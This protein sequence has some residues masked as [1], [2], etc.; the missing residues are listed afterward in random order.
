MTEKIELIKN[1]SEFTKLFEKVVNASIGVIMV[2]TREPYRA[3]DTLRRYCAERHDPADSQSQYEFILWDVLH[4]LQTFANTRKADGTIVVETRPTKNDVTTVDL[5]KAFDKISDNAQKKGSINTINVLFNPQPFFENVSIQQHIK[6]F[7]Q[8]ALECAHRIVMLCQEGADIPPAIENDVF[9]I[10]YLTPSMSELYSIWE[11]TPLGDGTPATYFKHF[12]K[13]EVKKIIQNAMGMSASEFENALAF[14]MTDLGEILLTKPESVK[15]EYIIDRLLKAKTDIIKKTDIL[16]L[17]HVGDLSNVGGLDLLKG[18]LKLRKGI[19][20]DKAK[21]FGIDSPKGIMLVGSPGCVDCD[22]EYFNGDKWVPIKDYQEGDF[23]LQYNKDGTA[24]MVKPLAYIKGKAD[25]YHLK[26]YTGSLDQVLSL[27]HRVIYVTSK[28]NIA[29]K[30]FREIKNLVNRPYGFKASIMH[31]FVCTDSI[32][33][34]L[35]PERLRLLIAISADGHLLPSGK[36]W[37]LNIKKERKKERL[38]ELINAVGLP[39]DERVKTTGFSEFFVPVEYGCKVFPHYFY[40]LPEDLK[41]VF[42]EEVV[43]WDGSTKGGTRNVELYFTTIKENADLVQFLLAQNGT[44][45]VI[46]EDNRV[47]K[48][49]SKSNYT[50]KTITYTVSRTKT[51][52]TSLLNKPNRPPITITNYT[53]K[54]GYQYCFRVPSG[55]LVLR[56]NN[57]IFITGNSGKSLCAKAIAGEFGLP[58]VKLDIGRVFSQYVGQSEQRMRKALSIVDALGNCVLFMDEVDKGLAGTSGSGDSGTTSRVFG[59]L[60]TWLQERDKNS[61]VFLV[62][63]ANNI[64]GLPPEL[65]RK[66]RFDEIFYVG[67]PTLKERIEIFKIHLGK[68]GHTKDINENDLK[69]VAE[70]CDKFS[71]AE[72]EQ[73]VVTGL[74]EAFSKG[75]DK[76]TME[77]LI[78]QAK[79]TIPLAISFKEK[80]DFMENWA[81]QNA[82]PASSTITKETIEPHRIRK[83]NI[84]GHNAN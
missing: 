60:L 77:N 51:K 68:R 44:R 42:C 56:R 53:A 9:V 83:L 43:L 27:D 38:R 3:I 47:G 16:E 37:R 28:G 54:D 4:G 5:K 10:D 82:K 39:V 63:T 11:N 2:R 25:L 6:Q 84:G 13:E 35:T 52:H 12:S 58:L 1:E 64:T 36:K 14:A 59:T 80:V 22:T 7:T 67:L 55:M 50:Y 23:V 33:T 31:N 65:M 49:H 61:T 78:N 21:D 24:N 17:M 26:N 57:N 69:T 32:N 71:G 41:K 15:P 19:F 62:T 18:W 73:V 29:E 34:G 45:V 79:E 30:P 20:S 81:K 46:H 48:R 66:G 72:I 76:V 70:H 74:I 8:T 75:Q 40:F